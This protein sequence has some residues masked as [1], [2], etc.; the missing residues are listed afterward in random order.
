VAASPATRLRRAQ[1]LVEFILTFPI[2]FLIVGFLIQFVLIV[3]A[4]SQLNL[5]T[6]CAARQYANTQSSDRM[7]A[8]GVAIMSPVIAYSPLSVPQVTYPDTA[9]TFGQGYLIQ[10]KA[11]VELLPI[12]IV[13]DIFGLVSRMDGLYEIQSSCAMTAES[14]Q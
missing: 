12:P 3:N 2:F 4:H 7:E 13:R 8:L 1:T 5:F 6:F 14:P 10:T 9:P 11:Q